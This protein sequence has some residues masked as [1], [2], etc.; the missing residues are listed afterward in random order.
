MTIDAPEYFKDFMFMAYIVYTPLIFLVRRI[1]RGDCNKL[2][3]FKFFADWLGLTQ[4]FGNNRIDKL[5]ST[6]T[7]R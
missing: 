1:A 3:I 2:L 6:L 5:E 4:N 7:E